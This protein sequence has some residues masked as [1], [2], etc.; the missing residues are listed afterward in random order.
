MNN[1]PIDQKGQGGIVT[2]AQPVLP[3]PSLR[4]IP[5]VTKGLPYWKKIWV[6]LTAV[7]K[8]EV[9]EN[10]LF[11]LPN[12][13]Y[14]LIPRGFI[15]DGASTPKFLWGILDPVGVLLIQGLIHDHGYRFNYLW[16]LDEN[17]NLCKMYEGA[18]RE[19]WDDLFLEIGNDLL[20]MQVTG[21]V[22][23]A[24]LRSFGW[25]AWERNRELAQADIVIYY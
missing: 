11:K 15:F 23:W 14:I 5:I 21:W 6:L 19:F 25:L 22:S 12:G 10:W 24:M 2:V 17:R 8:W 16:A 7:R 13:K 4:P 20:D 1:F 9:T 3:M 18:G